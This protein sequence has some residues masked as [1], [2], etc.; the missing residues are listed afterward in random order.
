MLTIYFSGTGNTKYIAELFSQNMDINCLSIEEEFNFSDKLNAHDTIVF[1]YPIYGSRVPRIM[2]E[3]VTKHMSA[4]IG[5]K[6]IILVTQMMFSGDGARVFTDMFSD[7]SIDVIY[8]EHFNMPNNICNFPLLKKPSDKKMQ[9]C[10]NKVNVKMEQV[11]QNIKDGIVIKRGFSQ[12]SQALGYIQGKSWQGDSKKNDDLQC[13]VTIEQKA[14]SGV[15]INEDCTVCNLCI[16]T[17]P[18]GNL[19]SIQNEIKQKGNCTVCYRCV[20]RC[21]RKAITVMM[22]HRKPKWQYEGIQY[23]KS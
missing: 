16:Y 21:P 11:C 23:F 13:K 4:I 15:K 14:K 12:F 7:G 19:E 10:F 22:F 5:K 3:F 6:I 18:T 1:C 20:N 17:C 2:R 9:K 8:A